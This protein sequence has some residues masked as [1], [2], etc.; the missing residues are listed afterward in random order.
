MSDLN[1]QAVVY[2]IEEL[3]PLNGL[4][5]LV[6]TN[7]FGNQVLVGVETKVGDLGLYFPLE[8]QIGEE[9]CIA[10]DLLRRKDE[11]G[12]VIGGMFD[13]NRRVRCQ[14]FR[15]NPS[16]GFWIPI[17]SLSY[18]KVDLP[19]EGETFNEFEGQC[20]SKKY[21]PR[22][23][24]N[25]HTG[26]GNGKPKRKESR[27]IKEYFP[28]HVHTDHLFKNLVKVR[29]GNLIIFTWKLHGTSGRCGNVQVRPKTSW[30]RKLMVNWGISKEKQNE[31]AYLYGSRQVVKDVNNPDQNHYYGTDLWTEIGKS[32]FDGKLHKNEM[33]FYEAVGYVPGTTKQIQKG[34]TYGCKEGQ[35][36]IYVYRITR[37]GVD[38]SWEAVKDRCTELGVKHVPEVSDKGFPFSTK[39]YYGYQDLEA[40]VKSHMLET[41][42]HLDSSHVEEGVVLR[43]EGLVPQFYKAKSFR[44]LEHETKMLDQEVEDIEEQQSVQEES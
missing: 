27:V 28:E 34:F 24:S 16:M 25:N 11:N 17:E 7:I 6:G 22:R 40:F 36:D 39:M 32:Y 21:I 3:H 44:F 19:K 29:T 8:S 12:K 14:K 2:R 42:C 31:Y 13:A 35:C 41:D 9:F 15:G 20:I 5:R 26:L 43:I 23:N 30:L 4:D 18:L 37:D 10:N 1:Y 33:V 38:L